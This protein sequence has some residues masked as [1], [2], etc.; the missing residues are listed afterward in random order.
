MS[1]FW[2]GWVIV[3]ALA[4][5]FGCVWL[6]WWASK[7]KQG[8][9]AKGDVT[10]HTWDD[11]LQELNNPM[12]RWWLWLFYITIVFGLAYI[13]IYPGLGSYKGTAG[14]SQTG[15][16]EEEMKAAN[17]TYGPIFSGYAKQDADS[18]VSNK[19]AMDSGRRL[20]MTYCSTCHGSDA[21]GSQGFPNLS[22]NDWIYGGQPEQIKASILDGRRGVMPSFA[23]LGEKG[24]EEVTN[25][26]MTLSGRKADEVKA[27]AGKATFD[28]QCV[29]CH[30][31]DAKGNIYIGAPNLTDKTW[32][33][34]STKGH[35][36]Q[37]I[38]KGRNGVMPA[39]RDFLGEDKVH[40]LS[41][42]IYS[43]SK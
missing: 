40:L 28:A 12:P 29:A 43:L 10:G 2:S 5:I 3:I 8:E 24:I 16:Y 35:I 17:E 14:W 11:D 6:I 21:R 39:H 42:Y 23:H 7:P 13:I 38:T 9:A 22:D 36:V 30:G 37:S 33:Y 20:F 18:L 4:N 34:G 41:A 26:V 25:H 27:A 19:M 1:N 31:A 15:Q 32:L